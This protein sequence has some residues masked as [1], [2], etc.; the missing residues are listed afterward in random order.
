[1]TP[2]KFRAIG[3]DKL[4]IRI[5]GEPTTHR[6]LPEHDTWGRFLPAIIVAEPELFTSDLLRSRK[7]GTC[8]VKERHVFAHVFTNMLRSHVV[9]FLAFASTYGPSRRTS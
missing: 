9:L 2:I 1:M 4:G 3:D 7:S 5:A 8:F 6:V